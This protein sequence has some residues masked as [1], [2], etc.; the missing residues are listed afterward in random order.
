MR[1]VIVYCCET[2][3]KMERFKLQPLSVLSVYLGIDNVL[4]LKKQRKSVAS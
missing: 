2:T 4:E 1:T 3:F